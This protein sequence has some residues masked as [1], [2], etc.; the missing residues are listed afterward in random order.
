M[1]KSLTTALNH[2]GPRECSPFCQSFSLAKPVSVVAAEICGMDLTDR[3]TALLCPDISVEEG[4]SVID[5]AECFQGYQGEEALEEMFLTNV[6]F[7]KKYRGICDDQCQSMMTNMDEEISRVLGEAENTFENVIN[8]AKEEKKILDEFVNVFSKC[9]KLLQDVRDGY[10]EIQQ[11]KNQRPEIRKQIDQ[12]I[13]DSKYLSYAD[14][15]RLSLRVEK[16]M[17]FDAHEPTYYSEIIAETEQEITTMQNK[18]I[19]LDKNRSMMSKNFEKTKLYLKS[20]VG[21]YGVGIMGK[22]GE[23]V[24][25]ISSAITKF[26]S[27]DPKQV[28]TGILDVAAAISNFLPPPANAIMGPLATIFGGLFGMGEKSPQQ[29]IQEELE[30]LKTFLKQEFEKVDQKLDKVIKEARNNA[31]TELL[32]DL[33]NMIQFLGGLQAYVQ[34]LEDMALNEVEVQAFV[35]QVND[36]FLS[37]DSFQGAKT[38]TYLNAYCTGDWLNKADSSGVMLPC[39][40]LVYAYSKMYI[41]R[42][43]LFTRFIAFIKASP[44]SRLTESNLRVRNLMTE[45]IKSFLLTYLSTTSKHGSAPVLGCLAS[46]HSAKLHCFR[47]GEISGLDADKVDFFEY[48]VNYL[49]GE[50]AFTFAKCQ[51]HDCRE[52]N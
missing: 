38:I 46:G 26:A 9:G 42:N 5:E 34:P 43:V 48:L 33:S 37:P 12:M 6:E 2:L 52:Y 15:K 19:D 21:P 50:S 51:E 40:D 49:F 45:E 39:M 29:V 30:K 47:G 4:N 10:W 14:K 28:F 23:S 16:A 22:V 44:L 1:H 27:G 24:S 20:Q 18:A 36:A 8:N 25:S 32:G 13:Y 31:I 11:A 35:G 3:A 7:S 41:L 17:D